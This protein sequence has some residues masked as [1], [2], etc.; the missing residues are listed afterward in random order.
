MK[1]GGPQKA[2]QF[3]WIVILLLSS[4][5]CAVLT[6][7]QVREVE[8]F[9]K[10]TEEFVD[11]PAALPQTYGLLLR[12]NVLLA[13]SR[14]EFGVRDDQRR[15]DTARANQAWEDVKTAYNLER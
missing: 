3:F 10:A 7:S 4:A 6:S 14:Y 8:N 9:T 2:V 15:V 11:L 1:P 12:N 13:V 5:G